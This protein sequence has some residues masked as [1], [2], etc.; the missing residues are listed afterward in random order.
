MDETFIPGVDY[1]AGVAVDA[2]HIWWT[3]KSDL[4]ACQNLDAVGRANL[5]GSS[6]DTHFIPLANASVYGGPAV[7]SG[8]IYWPTNSGTAIA[9]APIAGGTARDELHPRDAQLARRRGRPGAQSE[10]PA[11]TGSVARRSPG[12]RR[13][14]RLP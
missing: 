6:P 10:L 1:P 7:D 8:H 4:Q 9:R 12:G 13:H 5:D 2:T 11:R 14:D 3:S